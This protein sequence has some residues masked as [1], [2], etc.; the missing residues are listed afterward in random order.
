MLAVDYRLAPEHPAPAA[1][2]DAVAV[3]EWVASG[4]A[5][6]GG[7]P[8]AT[9]I[10]GDSAGGTIAALAALRQ[11]HQP[12]CPDVL[13][14]CYANTDLDAD[15]ESMQTNAHGYGLDV[16]DIRWF[17]SL[18]VPDR[19]RWADPAVS[20]LRVEDLHGLPETLVVTCELD[21][22]RDQGEAFACR[23]ADASVLVTLRREPGMVHNF[24]LWDL[25][26]PACATAADR[27]G[28]DIGAA[29]R[30]AARPVRT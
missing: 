16:A 30:R 9:A 17:N 24:L 26:S 14:L 28:D 5:E 10:A 20:P 2:D 25:I 7:R 8:R 21:P 29:L 12:S 13:A 27:V 18:W 22:L 11:R 3:L 19:S 15:D 1:I 6:L 23:L 4:P